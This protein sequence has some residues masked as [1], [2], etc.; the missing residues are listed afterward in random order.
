M[1]H[2]KDTILFNIETAIK[3]AHD[4]ES[5]KAAV[6]EAVRKLAEEVAEAQSRAEQK[7]L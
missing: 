1:A 2:S 7:R 4:L 5:L 6:L 3:E